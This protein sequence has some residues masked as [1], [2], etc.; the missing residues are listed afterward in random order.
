MARCAGGDRCGPARRHG[1]ASAA[2]VS[3]GWA[4]SLRC[5]GRPRRGRRRHSR[6]L[7]SQ[8]RS[9]CPALGHPESLAQVPGMPLA[10]AGPPGPRTESRRPRWRGP[11]GQPGKVPAPGRLNHSS[12]FSQR[13]DVQGQGAPEWGQGAPSSWPAEGALSLCPRRRERER[14]SSGLCLSLGLRS[15]RWAPPPMTPQNPHYLHEGLASEYPHVGSRCPHG[16]WAAPFCPAHLSGCS[17][18]T[19]RASPAQSPG[20]TG[21]LTSLCPWA[22]CSASEMATSSRRPAALPGWARLSV[23]GFPR[24]TLP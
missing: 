7:P 22:P 20:H 21:L 6:P 10:T 16:S 2:Y 24:L 19:L 5:P 11:P 9:T 8:G 15:Q 3:G 17:V 18:S 4:T 1:G 14:V 12:A 23:L 13:P